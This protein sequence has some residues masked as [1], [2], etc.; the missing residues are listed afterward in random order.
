MEDAGL[1][2]AYRSKPELEAYAATDRLLT[3]GVPLPGPRLD[4]DELVALEPAL[5]PGLA[6]GWYYDD[7]AHLRPDKLMTSW[8]QVARGRRRDDP[9]TLSRSRASP[10][11]QRP[12]RVGR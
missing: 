10:A 9:R 8:R 3:R 2:F 7:D 11:T 5:K 12:G 4:G 6:G 1:L